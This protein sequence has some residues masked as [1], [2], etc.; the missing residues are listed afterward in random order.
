MPRPTNP[1]GLTKL[2][3]VEF[4]RL[5]ALRYDMRVH[6]ARPF[7]FIGP[8][9]YPDACS[10]FAKGIVAVE[11]GR[12]SEVSVGSLDVVRD[13]LDV[14]DGVQA[15]WLIAQR[16]SPGEIFNICSGT[17]YRLRNILQQLTALAHTSVVV[18]DDPERARPLDVPVIVGDNSKLRRLG[19]QPQIPI[20]RTL[21][22]ILEYWR[23][24]SN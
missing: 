17:G 15:M 24:V 8:R 7:Q 3:S 20:G 11:R 1:Y 10:E 14:R 13:L 22:G 16:A 4:G 18:R 2:V 23:S 21:A 12:A 9:K 5:Y 6:A 19:W